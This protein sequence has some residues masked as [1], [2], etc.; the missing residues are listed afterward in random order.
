M[1]QSQNFQRDVYSDQ[2]FKYQVLYNFTFPKIST[3]I[4]A[5]Q[6]K[7]HEKKTAH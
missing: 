7:A 2:H 3:D 5:K 4:Y 1:L 6:D